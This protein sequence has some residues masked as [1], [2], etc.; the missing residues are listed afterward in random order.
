MSRVRYEIAATLRT[1]SPLHVGSGLFEERKAVPGKDGAD[2]PQVALIVRDHAGAPYLPPT[3]LK[4]LLRRV[5]IETGADPGMLDELFGTIKADGQGRM[6]ALTVR[7]AERIP[8]V[9]DARAAPF[10]GG[11]ADPEQLGPGVFIAARTR[12]DAT[13]G[14]VRD[15]TLFFQEMV[16]PGTCFALRCLVEARGAEAVALAEQRLH[17][18]LGLLRHLAEVGGALGKGY[19]DGFGRIDLDA[20][21]VRVTKRALDAAGDFPATDATALWAATP[22]VRAE[23]RV[24]RLALHCEGPFVVMDASRKAERRPADG[25]VE[26]E[27]ARDGRTLRAPQLQTQRLGTVLPLLLGS[28]L[29]GALRARARWLATCDALRNG[30]DPDAVDPEGQRPVTKDAIKTLTPVQRLFGVTGFRGLLTIG[31]LEVPEATPWTVTSVKLD[32]F[33]GAPVDNA[34][35]ATATF[36]GVRIRLELRLEERVRFADDDHAALFERLV[37]DVRDRGIQLGHGGNKGFGW[38]EHEGSGHAG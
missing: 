27:R 32:R 3:T 28:S 23:V 37:A 19:A 21:S 26:E 15:A 24:E 6:G 17:L 20:D 1:V 29:S 18:L 2:P 8:P 36:I 25:M 7:G 10:T 34:L 14:T 22:S 11:V 16:A 5:A 13:T 35:F 30:G 38:F 12:I 33:S 4:S 9:P 31:R